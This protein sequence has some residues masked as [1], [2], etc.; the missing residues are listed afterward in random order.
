MNTFF[1]RTILL[2]FAALL[3]LAA[4]SD[5][6]DFNPIPV[7]SPTLMVAP[8]ARSSGMG[9]VGVATSPDAAS[10]HWNAAKYA[11][12]EQS[13]G[14]VLGYSPWLRT[15]VPDVNIAYLSF[16]WKYRE[17]EAAAITLRYFSLGSM[18]IV[19]QYATQTAEASPYEV[20]LDIAWTR[21]FGDNFSASLTGRYIRSDLIGGVTPVESGYTMKPA[22]AFSF[23]VGA[24]Y[25]RPLG[26]DEMLAFGLALTNL[27]TKVNYS[28]EASGYFLPM[29]MRLGAR[30]GLPIDD[31]NHISFA[32]DINKLLVPTPADRQ[33]DTLLKNSTSDVSVPLAIIKSFGDAPFGFA[34]ELAEINFGIGA[35]YTYRNTFFGRMGF[36]YDSKRKGN[37]RYMSFGAGLKYNFLQLDI[38]Y[39]VPFTN[40]D[41]MANTVKFSLAMYM[42]ESK[43]SAPASYTPRRPRD[44]SSPLP[45]RSS[46]TTRRRTTT[47]TNRTNR[48]PSSTQR[49]GTTQQRST[50]QQPAAT[51]RRTTTQQKTTT[52]TTQ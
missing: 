25:Q 51:Q 50:T 34:E 6:K 26:K 36:Y 47:P 38:A 17:L 46:D 43:P 35:E 49:T 45:S 5:Q 27:G 39:Y 7:A 33:N 15:L 16:F 52:K 42:G 12:I 21:R 41:P 40:N 48:T 24:Y 44:E 32:A 10:Q 9:D 4:Y 13:M 11:F 20:A 22:N 8:D 29:N 1:S 28:E 3:P 14:G 19:D 23:D 37:R 2:S 30:Y 31:D 18:Q